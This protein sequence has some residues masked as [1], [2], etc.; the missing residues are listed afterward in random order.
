MV[1]KLKEKEHVTWGCFVNVVTGFF[2]NE[3]LLKEFEL[4]LKEHGIKD[5]GTQPW[6]AILLVLK[7]EN[8]S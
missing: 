6:W 8:S 4:E 2:G 7:R 1:E 3:T 5:V